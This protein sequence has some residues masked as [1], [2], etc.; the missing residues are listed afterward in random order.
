MEKHLIQTR[1]T[2]EEFTQFEKIAQN[3]CRSIAS[4]LLKVIRE[5][6]KS[7]NNAKKH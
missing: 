5:Y 4:L 6:L 7:T 3:E 2:K 1:I